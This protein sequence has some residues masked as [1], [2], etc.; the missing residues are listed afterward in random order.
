MYCRNCGRQLS[1]TEKFCC[2]CGTKVDGVDFKSAVSSVKRSASQAAQ[3]AA[4]TV[5]S[6]GYGAKVASAFGSLEKAKPFFIATVALLLLNFFLT[7]TDMI[8]FSFLFWG[9][10]GTFASCIKALA[11]FDGSDSAMKF[12][13]FA[14]TATKIAVL[15]AAVLTVLP[16]LLGKKTEKKFL[17]LNYIACAASFVLYLY[18]TIAFSDSEVRD[19]V[20]IKF[21]AYFYLVVTLAAIVCTA[22]LSKKLGAAPAPY[23]NQVFEQAYAQP[24]AQTV[25][26]ERCGRSVPSTQSRVIRYAD[27]DHLFCG[28]CASYLN[29]PYSY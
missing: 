27:G 13:I 3:K 23:R 20:E 16:V 8:K 15:A 14:F 26:C 10:S 9:D 6:S 25:L 18:W 21:T 12:G 5:K 24:E 17:I 2:Q 22:L 11:E 28:E 1:E 7:F 29:N 4:T 19:Y